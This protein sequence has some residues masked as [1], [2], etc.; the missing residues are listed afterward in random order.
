LA[1]DERGYKLQSS[2]FTLERGVEVAAFPY[3]SRF[4]KKG[5]NFWGEPMERSMISAL[6]FTVQ[7]L[8]LNV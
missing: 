6:H 7:H 8:K 3:A 2:I 4:L 1:L 5:I